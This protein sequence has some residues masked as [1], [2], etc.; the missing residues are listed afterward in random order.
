MKQVWTFSDFHYLM[1]KINPLGLRDESGS[2]IIFDRQADCFLRLLAYVFERFPQGYVEIPIIMTNLQ[3]LDQSV[4][5]SV[6]DRCDTVLVPTWKESPERDKALKSIIN[7]CSMPY[8]ITL[9]SKQI[10]L[11]LF[12]FETYLSKY[13][14]QDKEITVN[15]K[16]I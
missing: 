13:N 14:P 5:Y 1:R 6:C 10:D 8:A 16:Q 4:I 3:R 7:I 12:Y 15:I 2:L 11:A 9:D